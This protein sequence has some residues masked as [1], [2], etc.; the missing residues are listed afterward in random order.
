MI[1]GTNSG[2]TLD[3]DFLV[4]F[5]GHQILFTNHIFFHFQNMLKVLVVYCDQPVLMACSLRYIYNIRIFGILFTSYSMNRSR[6][7]WSFLGF[8]NV[9]VICSFIVHVS[10]LFHIMIFPLYGLNCLR[11]SL[12]VG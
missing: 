10:F 7:F 1:I 9:V 5:L 11:I 2:L 4:L 8:S 3:V 6:V 12:V